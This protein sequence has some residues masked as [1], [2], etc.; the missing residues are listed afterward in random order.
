MADARAEPEGVDPQQPGRALTPRRDDGGIV[1]G[2]LTKLVVVMAV[3]GVILFDGL[4]ITASRLSIEDHGFLAA[5]EASSEW[6]RS[7]DVQLAYDSALSTAVDANALNEV[8]PGSFVAAPDGTVDLDIHREAATL[9]VHRV[10]WIADWA[11]V[12]THAAAKGMG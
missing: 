4:S 11:L 7:G 2:W 3:V 9:V 8:P 5:R 10:G 6:Q 12:S 1:L